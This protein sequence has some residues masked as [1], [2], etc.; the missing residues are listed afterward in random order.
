MLH[1]LLVELGR[2]VLDVGLQLEVVDVGDVV[3]GQSVPL[4]DEA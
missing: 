4:E 2:E 3:V 1:Q